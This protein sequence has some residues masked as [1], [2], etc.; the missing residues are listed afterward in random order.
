MSHA[1]SD[2]VGN[3]GI[4]SFALIHVPTTCTHATPPL[5]TIGQPNCRKSMKPGDACGL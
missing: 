1:H 5:P 4:L 2:I 3:V